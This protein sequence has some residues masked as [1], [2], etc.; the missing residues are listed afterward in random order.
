MEESPYAKFRAFSAQARDQGLALLNRQGKRVFVLHFSYGSLTVLA[1]PS[2]VA[3]LVRLAANRDLRPSPA[4]IME[5]LDLRIERAELLAEGDHYVWRELF[6]A[7]SRVSLGEWMQDHGYKRQ[8]LSKTQ[9][10]VKPPPPAIDDATTIK[11]MRER[12]I[13]YWI[14]EG[15]CE[16]DVLDEEDEKHLRSVVENRV[17][18]FEDAAM[19]RLHVLYEKVRHEAEEECERIYREQVSRGRGSDMPPSPK[20]IGLERA[21]AFLQ[22]ETGVPYEPPDFFGRSMKDD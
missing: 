20:D 2:A 1:E 11:T 18:S 8:D 3:A 5:L 10:S 17:V 14:H 4:F 19:L 7:S 15:S 12:L 16:I 13:E 22:I 21:L 6:E 9:A